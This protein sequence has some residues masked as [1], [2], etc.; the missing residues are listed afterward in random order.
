MCLFCNSVT[1]FTASSWR[2]RFLHPTVSLAIDPYR[3][4]TFFSLIF[5]SW[6]L[7]ALAGHCWAEDAVWLK[8]GEWSALVLVLAVS[9]QKQREGK[10]FHNRTW[11]VLRGEDLVIRSFHKYFLNIHHVNQVH[12]LW[13]HPS[14]F[15]HWSWNIKLS[16]T[17][18][19]WDMYYKTWVEVTESQFSSK[20]PDQKPQWSDINPS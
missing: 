11:M 1:A 16:C 10:Y 14:I 3:V 2:F 6:A 7:S 4:R 18:V 9:S 19:P 8:V 13:L 12:S 5:V 17:L 15:Y 20:Q